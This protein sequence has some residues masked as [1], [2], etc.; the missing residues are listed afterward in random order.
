[1]KKSLVSSLALVF[2][3]LLGAR[4]EAFGHRGCDD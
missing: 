2:A 4:A 3:G 1:M